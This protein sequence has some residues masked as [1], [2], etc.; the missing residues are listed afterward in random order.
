MLVKY[1]SFDLSVCEVNRCFTDGYS[2]ERSE[3]KNKIYKLKFGYG[4]LG[5][6]IVDGTED[7]VLSSDKTIV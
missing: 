7:S 4:K 2:R 3:A 6:C 5:F 1:D